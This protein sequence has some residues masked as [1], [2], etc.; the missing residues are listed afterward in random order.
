[1][2]SYTIVP[3]YFVFL[4]FLSLRCSLGHN[5]KTNKCYAKGRYN[6]SNCYRGEKF[7]DSPL[8]WRICI[9]NLLLIMRNLIF[10]ILFHFQKLFLLQNL[11]R[12]PSTKLKVPNWPFS[13]RHNFEIAII[14]C[15]DYCLKL[16]WPSL[17]III[18]KRYF[19]IWP[20]RLGPQTQS[21]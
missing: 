1:M 10:K 18:S 16:T 15:H 14:L 4:C 9:C 11:G 21:S 6:A 20:S 12:G 8:F 5:L 2:K 7:L 3:S 19:P 17:I 13:G